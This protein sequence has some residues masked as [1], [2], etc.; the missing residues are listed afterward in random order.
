MATEDWQFFLLYSEHA[1]EE[2]TQWVGHDQGV[3]PVVRPRRGE[4]A[5][6]QNGPRASERA[7]RP[8]LRRSISGPM[9]RHL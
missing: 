8:G 9:R 2:T 5:G 4:A 1:P 3:K 7:L 6:T